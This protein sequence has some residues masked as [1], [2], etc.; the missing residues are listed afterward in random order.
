MKCFKSVVKYKLSITCLIPPTI[1]CFSTPTLMTELPKKPISFTC[2]AQGG[3]S[4]IIFVLYAHTVIKYWKLVFDQLNSLCLSSTLYITCHK[5]FLWTEINYLTLQFQ[6]SLCATR[7]AIIFTYG[8]LLAVPTLLLSLPKTDFTALTCCIPPVSYTHLDVYKRQF[9]GLPFGYTLFFLQIS[10]N[11][12]ITAVVLIIINTKVL[13]YFYFILT[14]YQY[15][16]RTPTSLS[17]KPSFNFVGTFKEYVTL[18]LSL[19]H[20]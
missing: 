2:T 15:C 6:Q 13:R 16:L 7:Y 11:I 17:S 8:C 9:L 14:V 12:I 3:C 4:A 19:I 20:I 5:L 1:S 10:R 18:T